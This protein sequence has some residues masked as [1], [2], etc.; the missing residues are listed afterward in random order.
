MGD[1]KPRLHKKYTFYEMV[2]VYND[3]LYVIGCAA[4]TF[5]LICLFIGACAYFNMRFTDSGMVRNFL[6]GGV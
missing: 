5:L 4:L 3:V 6:N 1:K 2:T